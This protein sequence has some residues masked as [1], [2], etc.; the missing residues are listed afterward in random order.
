ML[1]LWH[2][3][4]QS[5]IVYEG[6]SRKLE[7]LYGIFYNYVPLLDFGCF[8]LLLALLGGLAACR[9]LNVAPR[10]MPAILLVLLA[11]LLLPTEM[12]GAWATDQR[13]IVAFFLLLV[14]AAAPDFPSRRIALLTGTA[15]AL[16]LVVRLGLVEAV[17]LEADPIY[18][19]DFAG[20]DLL[21][22]GTKLAVA[23]PESALATG[24]IPE[25]HLPT[26]AAA[27]RA[28]F[29]P[30]LFAFPG[31][32]PTALKPP[33]DYLAAVAF[34]FTLWSAFIDDENAARR[35]TLAALAG[36]DAV[37]FVNHEPFQLPRE[38]CLKPLFRRPTF[39]IFTLVHGGDC[40]EQ[41]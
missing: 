24:T 12:F 13:I 41:Q 26:L 36:Y 30:T 19:A 8:F 1:A 37:V 4:G 14:A 2:P 29:V 25:I 15:I 40:P 20:L 28:A 9:R 34:P 31:Q 38:E 33:Y 39:Q 27:R 21:P 22:R 23:Y 32:Q 11:Y 10:L 6:W 3:A 16:V 17:W 7:W 18:R 5:R 35:R